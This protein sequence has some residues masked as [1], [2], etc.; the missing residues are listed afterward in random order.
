MAHG[1]AVY[2]WQAQPR[3]APPPLPG[4]DIALKAPPDVPRNLSG[5]LVAKL[6]P[7][8]MLVAAVGMLALF[9]TSGTP[10][11]SPTF[12]VFPAMMVAST[13]A[14]TLQHG[15]GGSRAADVDEDRKDYLQYLIERRHQSVKDACAQ[16]ESLLWQHPD[17]SAL[18]TLAG[19]RRMW[20]RRRGDS[21]F[22][23]IRVG[24][25]HQ[26]AAVRLV[27]PELAPIEQLEPVGAAALAEFVR[28]H[29]AVADV[30]IAIALRRFGIVSVC[31][32]AAHARS[33]L[34]AMLCQV[35][36][37]HGPDEVAVVAVVDSDSE[38][39]WEWLKWLPHHRHPSAFDI[40]GARRLR[41]SR[42][43]QEDVDEIVR[44][45]PVAHLVVV[46]DG[47]DIDGPCQVP[48]T[49][50]E[51]G[52]RGGRLH[53][54]SGEVLQLRVTEDALTTGGADAEEF[55][56]PDSMTL[57]QTETCA[58]RLAR[59]G[60]ASPRGRVT[61]G[62]GWLATLGI[63]IPNG[64]EPSRAWGRQ[65]A[66]AD[67]LRVPV[68]MGGDGVPVFLDI[69]EAA[70]GGMGPHGLCVGAT[71]SGKSEFLRTFVIGLMTTHSPDSLNLVL[72]DFKG[73]ATFAGFESARHVAAVIT[74]LSDAA[75]LVLR[76]KD[77]LAGEMYRR[78]EMLRLAGNFVSVA[79]YER[80]RQ[81]GARLDPLPAL[82]VIV[83]EF[84]ELLAQHP[85]FAETFVAI[86]RLGRSLRIH[87]L[88]A[89][90]RLDEGRLRGLESHLSYRICLKTFS[91]GESRAVIGVPDAFHLP[92]APGAAYL[93]TGPDDPRRFQVAYA[94]GHNPRPASLVDRD[95]QRVE[96]W[97]FTAAPM[98]EPTSVAMQEC[99]ETE[100]NP[101]LLHV[102]LGRLEGHGSA[103]HQ[104]WLPPLGP[105][106]TLD[107]LVTS[108]SV[109]E[110]LSVPIGVVDLPFDQ[111][112]D[113]LTVELGG[114]AGHIA[115]VGA[116]QSGKSTA[117]C[118]LLLALAATNSPADVQFYCLDFGGGLLQALAAVPH[119]GSV[120]ALTDIARVRRTV[121]EVTSVLRARE[122]DFRR[123]SVGSM[124]EFRRRRAVGDSLMDGEKYGD[125]FLVIDGWS[126]LRADFDALESAITALAARGL[127]YGIHLVLTASRWA[128][129]RP[130][131][132]DQIGTRIELRL[133]DAVDSEVDRRAAQSV[134]HDRPGRGIT[135]GGMHMQL[136]LPRLDGK[137]TADGLSESTAILARVLRARFGSCC[138]P[139]V[140]LLPDR[141]A[142]ADVLD[143]A[144]C[145]IAVGLDEQE[146][147]LVTIDFAE[148]SHL[149]ILGDNQCGKTA[150]LRL[151]CTEIVRT[152]GADQA[153]LMIVDFRRTLLGVVDSGHLAG[154]CGSSAVLQ[155]HMPALVQ[156]LRE[157]M[158]GP[159]VEQH[160][161][162]TRSWWSGPEIYL[163][164]DDYDLVAT[165][166]D[167]SLAPIIE[168][169]PYAGD[170][171]FHLVLAR[172]SGGAA[173]ALFDPVLARL[174]DV[175]CMGLMMS[176][177]PDEGPLLGT[178]RPAA[179]PPGRGSLITRN[180]ERLIQ[181]AWVTQCP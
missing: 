10:M 22:C 86:G 36:M 73:G 58:R 103:A 112:R 121:A 154:Y 91:A 134:P 168:L 160:Q 19:T 129:I 126:A 114:A 88:L 44:H 53:G 17:P 1:E 38:Q 45:R 48:T 118:T 62:F 81:R 138:A 153:Q 74:N 67:R 25:G 169:L 4:G 104:V 80:A 101:S 11:R 137:P 156:R 3:I 117:L 61:S 84:S 179:L 159:G 119:V 149:L 113:A 171:G 167:N 29:S 63:G 30:P 47:G 46:A 141:V 52:R 164:V 77:A 7:V 170:L 54:S 31:G 166:A 43:G 89:S 106:P 8:V 132:K 96:V 13:I 115:V 100:G 40:T 93:R 79:E 26:R 90:Q 125:V 20:E 98:N 180:G 50:L 176:A 99:A 39:Y 28:A 108:D 135:S 82:V 127:S 143:E 157:R 150:A 85:E 144:G 83:D 128:E 68:G 32:A 42:L 124:S 2:E 66:E 76:M 165:A 140:R 23:H 51:W 49:V 109:A 123:L 5:N 95:S 147:S 59:Y 15:R 136:A 71:G 133:G 142:Y 161:L 27:T 174:R 56:A 177:S 34:R 78:Q 172:R 33:L 69:K 24:R 35:A 107:A 116:P 146:L 131:L 163:V 14:M 158:P 178:S 148:Q 181:L 21:D 60:D 72:V 155:A 41:Y 173:R 94:S 16:H 151:L 152:H 55:G 110:T 18:W 87:L 6:M 75:P 37:L 111:R 175:G 162:K 120:A 57:E 12:F 65:R 92:T 64:W 9:L 130:G 70:D 122:R 97:R 145:D 105:S 139:P 102:L